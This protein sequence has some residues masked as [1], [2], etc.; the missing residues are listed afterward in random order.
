[1]RLDLH[2]SAQLVLNIGVTKLVL[3]QNLQVIQRASL[4]PKSISHTRSKASAI[5]YY[6]IGKQLPTFKA[7]MNLVCLSLARYTFPNL[8]RPRGF[9]M[10]K[11]VSCQRLSLSVL[12]T[13]L[14]LLTPVTEA[15]HSE[16]GLLDCARTAVCSAVLGGGGPMASEGAAETCC[17]SAARLLVCLSGALTLAVWL[18]FACFSAGCRAPHSAGRLVF[19]RPVADTFSCEDRFGL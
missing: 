15:F 6:D 3:E 9:P 5:S 18:N 7:I 10:S 1:M 17:G 11:S 8:P 19:N 14:L 2:L 12:L 13:E 4:K 16:A